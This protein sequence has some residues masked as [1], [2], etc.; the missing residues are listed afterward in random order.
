MRIVKANWCA[1]VLVGLLGMI[2]FACS[3]DGDSSAP[4]NRST[5]VNVLSADNGILAPL[6]ESS[7][8]K[9]VSAGDQNWE[10]TLTLE[11]V[12]ETSLWYT[13]RPERESGVETI[14]SYI[15]L[16]F[17]TYGQVSPNA[18]LDGY[19]I[20]ETQHDGL[21]LNL[22]AP[23]YDLNAKRLTFQV[24]LLGSS[25]ANQHPLVP[26]DIGRIKLTVLNNTPE[27]EP[28]YWTFGQAA[29]GAV[30]EPTG[31]DDLYRLYLIDFY[32]E[33]Y[34]LQNAPGSAY[35]INAVSSLAAHWQSYFGAIPPNASLSAYTDSGEL[36]L[37][38]LELDNPL[39]EENIFSYDARV[40]F[41]TVP[42]DSLTDA[43]LLT[44]APDAQ[45]VKLTLINHCGEGIQVLVNKGGVWKSGGV[46]KCAG[47]QQCSVASGDHLIDIGSSGMDF[48]I[49]S[50]S[51]NATKAEVTYL[52]ELSFDISVIADGGNCPNSCKESA[53]CEQHFNE[54]VKITPDAGCRCV[55]CDSVTCPDAFHY[56]TDNGK[57]VNCVASTAL[58]IEFCPSSECPSSGWRNCT[59]AEMDICHNQD[60]PCNGDQTICC[61]KPAYGGSHVCY[62]E[63][64]QPY[65]ASAPDPASPC[66]ADKENYCYV[67]E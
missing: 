40:L 8:E 24:T 65:C 39:Y 28:N 33:L 23:S 16:W 19:L 67:T 7:G 18:V 25:L 51:D 60:Q 2:C 66:G 59:S 6:I 45:P 12:S 42:N 32:P 64:K 63:T 11:N 10:Y 44:D 48:F 57:Q 3:S 56:P 37:F 52:T 15:Q 35:K 26:L 41:G 38:S 46:V 22:K 62:C 31:M 43:T 5:R 27:G 21:F 50:A 61:P 55:Y 30:L 13:D 54:T 17:K 1:V 49:G 29:Q 58:T 47:G 14:Q 9:I 20:T 34:Q 36:Q 53:C 4:S